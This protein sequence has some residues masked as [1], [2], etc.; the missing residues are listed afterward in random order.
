M[1]GLGYGQTYAQGTASRFARHVATD[2]WVLT[3]SPFLPPN[4]FGPASSLGRQRIRPVHLWLAETD[5]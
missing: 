4:T 1:P 3:L 5:A 2:T